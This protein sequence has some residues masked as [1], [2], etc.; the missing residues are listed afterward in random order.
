MSS[1]DLNAI[2]NILFEAEV[3]QFPDPPPPLSHHNPTAIYNTNLLLN[4]PPQ[5]P[6]Y[7]SPSPPTPA[8]INYLR[9]TTSEYSTSPSMQ[10]E[11]LY[12]DERPSSSHSQQREFEVG[13]G[14]DNDY[15]E[16]LCS[17]D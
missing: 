11:H 7:C 17:L 15:K 10:S 14:A 8:S 3:G 5:F 12:G 9:S 6:P 2:K 13:S 16:I 4:I 1:L